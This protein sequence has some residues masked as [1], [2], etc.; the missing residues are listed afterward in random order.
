MPAE[1]KSKTGA[2]VLKN[3]NEFIVKVSYQS[4]L[5]YHTSEIDFS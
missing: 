2:I 5:N 1:E 4:C 3:I